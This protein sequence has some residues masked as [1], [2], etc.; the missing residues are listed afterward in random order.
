M[1]R[2]EESLRERYHEFEVLNKIISAGYRAQTKDQFLNFLLNTLLSSLDFSGGAV[3]LIDEIEKKAEL[4][5][6]IGIPKNI[7]DN[8][9]SVSVNS[10]QFKRL[11]VEGQTI[12]LDDFKEIEEQ[13]SKS[14]INT[15]ISVPFFSK[16]RINGALSLISNQKR[17]ISESDVRLL[18]AIG[19]DVGTVLAKF[20]AEEELKDRG[21]NLQLIFDSLDVILIIADAT[22]LQILETNI[23]AQKRLGYSEAEFK[24]LT[25]FDLH[26]INSNTKCK[27]IMDMVAIDKSVKMNMEMTSKEGNQIK[28]ETTIQYQTFAGKSVYL[29]LNRILE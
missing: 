26:P 2:L 23:T 13:H 14:G 16:E 17:K 10:P 7:V 9:K 20:K 15:L 1:K 21:S 24:K 8:I 18:E 12:I 25:I 28:T 5:K 3:Y 11:F 27:D 19:R 4:D 29:C 6:H 22:S